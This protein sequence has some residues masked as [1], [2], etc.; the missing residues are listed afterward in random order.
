M[1]TADNVKSKIQGLINKSNETTGNA[2]TDLT[3]AVNSLVGGY[4]KGGGEQP[5]LFAPI[6]KAGINSFEWE[7]DTKN[8][9]FPV[10][11]SADVSGKTVTSPL[12]VTEDM[13]G[14]T[15][16]VTASADKFESASVQY[17]MSYMELGQS[18]LTVEYKDAVL[19]SVE[20]FCILADTSEI[21][22]KAS[23]GMSGVSG[24]RGGACVSVQNLPTETLTSDLTITFTADADC[25]IRI[26]GE[27]SYGRTTNFYVT[28]G[29]PAISTSANWENKII[30]SVIVYDNT[31][32]SVCNTIA[33]NRK[34]YANGRDI[35]SF[36]G[37]AG[38]SYSL[39]FDVTIEKK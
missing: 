12:S 13:G 39:I 18:L 4:G 34:S 20:W 38:H 25:P 17:S 37:K 7:N 23:C 9:G 11:I 35:G 26:W 22:D 31:S 2:D 3:S 8:G 27:W 33:F 28:D 15:L 24:K 19:P 30:G 5:I 16:T 10:D 1:A 6:V 32:E 29:T 36:N 21:S 14:K